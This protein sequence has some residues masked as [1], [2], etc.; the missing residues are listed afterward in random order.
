M[1][2]Y[3]CLQDFST[4]GVYSLTYRPA[5]GSSHGLLACMPLGEERNNVARTVNGL[6]AKLAER[7]VLAAMYDYPGMGES[8]GCAQE[9][10]LALCQEAGSR[11]L[12][13]VRARHSFCTLTIL[14][15]RSGCFTAADIAAAE[16][17]NLMLWLP[18]L[19][20]S[21][22]LRELRFKERIR[23]SLTGAGDTEAYFLNGVEMA[24][25]LRS[26]LQR[27]ESLFNAR[28][29]GEIRIVQVSQTSRIQREFQ[30]LGQDIAVDVVVSP[31]FWNPHEDWAPS[32]VIDHSLLWIAETR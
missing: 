31:P 14:G 15:V 3:A 2:E 16:G 26:E 19:T 10:T 12:D 32:S 23:G 20:G 6:L 9:L 24:A 8:C 18:F 28:A 22:F 13:R 1:Q 27:R 7:G 5:A 25:E 4:D 30:D 21:R 17:A 11:V 29:T